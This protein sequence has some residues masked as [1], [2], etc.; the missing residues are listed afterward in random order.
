MGH[1]G[2][3]DVLTPNQ[4]LTA[5]EHKT[6]RPQETPLCSPEGNEWHKSETFGIVF[7]NFYGYAKFK[8]DP[9]IA[10]PYP[11]NY[12]ETIKNIKEDGYPS[13]VMVVID[14]LL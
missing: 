11:S 14:V 7:Y 5:W 8:P 10:P 13:I 4:S 9:I 12:T 1:D 2:I 6:H 3:H